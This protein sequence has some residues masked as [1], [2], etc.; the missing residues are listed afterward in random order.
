MAMRIEPLRYLD[1]SAAVFVTYSQKGTYPMAN[2]RESADGAS[3]V[4]GSKIVLAEILSWVDGS[5]SMIE[6][7]ILPGQV[8][9]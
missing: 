4:M 3:A 2:V 9:R 8:V 6:P 1:L 7:C 5:K